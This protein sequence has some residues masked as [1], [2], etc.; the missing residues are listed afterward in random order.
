M[1]K[2]RFKIDVSDS[3]IGMTFDE[4]K[5]YCLSEGY[6]LYSSDDKPSNLNVTYIIT[7]KETDSKG[8]IFKAKYGI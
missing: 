4:A 8:K 5:I 2:K 3:I 7:V 1:S 6:R